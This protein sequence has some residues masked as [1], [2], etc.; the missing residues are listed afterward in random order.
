MRVITSN[1]EKCGVESAA[2]VIMFNGPIKIHEERDID[3]PTK[4][5]LRFIVLCSEYTSATFFG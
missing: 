1:N 4:H 3:K 5:V 2:V